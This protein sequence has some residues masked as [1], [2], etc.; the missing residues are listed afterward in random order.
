M[1]QMRRYNDLLKEL[2]LKDR[3]LEYIELLRTREFLLRIKRNT[4]IV[5]VGTQFLKEYYWQ[6]YINLGIQTK[7]P[8]SPGRCL[9]TVG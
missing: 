3:P 2:D 9:E 6:I 7:N 1:S 8:A 4:H 5:L